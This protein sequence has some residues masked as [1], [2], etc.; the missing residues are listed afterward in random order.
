MLASDPCCSSGNY[1]IGGAV[2]VSGLAIDV[3]GIP[4]WII[5]ANRKNA[6]SDS[7]VNSDEQPGSIQLAPDL[8]YS[9]FLNS[10]AVGITAS[11]RF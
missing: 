10:Y 4:V 9:P 2:L 11:V 3:I 6:L 7:Q 8:I 1:M 5:G